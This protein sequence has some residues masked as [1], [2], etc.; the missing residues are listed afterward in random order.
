MSWRGHPS[1]GD[2]YNGISTVLPID[3]LIL[4]RFPQ[5]RIPGP[6][7][8]SGLPKEKSKLKKGY[9]IDSAQKRQGLQAVLNISVPLEHKNPQDTSIVAGNTL[10]GFI[11]L[12]EHS[13]RQKV[14]TE[15]Y[16]EQ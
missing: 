8:P 14:P 10:N 2:P 11:W 15:P 3:S 13:V 12:S 1:F 5:F 4:L 6:H 16:R 7:V 9:S